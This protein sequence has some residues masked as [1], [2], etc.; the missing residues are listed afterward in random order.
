MISIIYFMLY[1]MCIMYIICY[2]LYIIYYILYIMYYILYIIHYILYNMGPLERL[3]GSLIF[4]FIYIGFRSLLRRFPVFLAP[5]SR[6]ALV[7]MEPLDH[8]GP[9]VHQFGSILGHTVPFC[10]HLLPSWL[11]LGAS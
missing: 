11:H 2:M 7:I 1:M 3:I 6:P 8:L 9:F 5:P 10:A 4:F